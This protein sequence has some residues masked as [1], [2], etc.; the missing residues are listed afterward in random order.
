MSQR[1]DRGIEHI[2]MIVRWLG[3]WISRNVS[4]SKKGWVFAESGIKRYIVEYAQTCLR[5]ASEA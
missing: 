1:E 2:V 4:M 5:S 3:V